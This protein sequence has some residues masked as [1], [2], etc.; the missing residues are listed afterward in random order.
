MNH[1]PLQGPRRVRLEFT[2]KPKGPAGISFS[3]D[4]KVTA[5]RIQL[6]ERF[7]QAGQTAFEDWAMLCLVVDDFVPTK[8]A[9]GGGAR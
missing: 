2:A 5:L 6:F 1:K 8:R 3:F 9:A 4:K 7:G